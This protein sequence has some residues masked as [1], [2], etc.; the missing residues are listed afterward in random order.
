MNTKRRSKSRNEENI[1]YIYSQRTLRHSL[2]T[3]RE[4]VRICSRGE[5][6]ERRGSRR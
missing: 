6:I 4:K 5:R 2:R 3:L 1:F